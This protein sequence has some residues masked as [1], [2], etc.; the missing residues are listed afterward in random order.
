MILIEIILIINEKII[1]A[2]DDNI[3]DNENSNVYYYYY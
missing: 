1:E 2:N 3:N